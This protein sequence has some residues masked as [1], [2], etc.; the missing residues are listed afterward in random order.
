M[1]RRERQRSRFKIL[2]RTAGKNL[3]ALTVAR[4][5]RYLDRYPEFGIAWLILGDALVDLA[6]YDEAESAYATAIRLYPGET[7]E[8]P[9]SCMGH[10]HRKRGDLDAAADWY[11]R[12]IEADPGVASPYIYLG[13][14]LALQGRLGEAEDAHRAA[15]RCKRGCLEEASLNLG[16]VLRAQG[17]LVEAVECFERALEFNPNDHRSHKPL[18]DVRKTLEYLRRVEGPTPSSDDGASSP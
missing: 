2:Q 5:R 18:A 4:A 15:T 8:I 17:R 7:L 10:L 6:H 13:A 11:R 1:N 14:V 12:A 3:P 9:L 16:L